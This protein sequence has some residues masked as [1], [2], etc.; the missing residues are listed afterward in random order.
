MQMK[1]SPTMILQTVKKNFQEILSNIHDLKIK[2]PHSVTI[3][4]V[5]KYHTTQHIKAAQ[6]AGIKNI[7]ESRV[8]EADKKLNIIKREKTTR[9][10]LIGHLQSN[11]TKKAVSLFDVI[12][13]VDSIRLAKKI[14]KES[15]KINKKQQVFLQINISKDPKKYGF[16]EEEALLGCAEIQKLYNIQVL[17]LMTI[18]AN[19]LKDYEL[20]KCYE[21]MR[22]LR[23][24]LKSE[25]L[26]LCQNLSMGMSRDY[27]YAIKEGA[28]HVR[29]GTGLFGERQ[30]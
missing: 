13:T 14:N 17:G 20:G 6:K 16:F 11:K 25:G 1:T 19:H 30:R 2:T 5:T 9:L 26:P 10:H 22:R 29:I 4:G 12:Q 24:K 7:G 8:Q 28:T 21:K 15:K 18:T 27:L 3:I 23:K